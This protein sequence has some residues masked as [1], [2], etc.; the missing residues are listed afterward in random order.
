M[1]KII[2]REFIWLIVALIASLPLGVVFL[3][4]FGY[5]REV[6][7][8]TEGENNYIFWMYLIGYFASFL[9]IYIM[10]FIAVSIKTLNAKE[11]KPAED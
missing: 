9:G 4:F 7:N 8:L 10:R 5:T 1:G 11:E 6:V 3:W 2:A